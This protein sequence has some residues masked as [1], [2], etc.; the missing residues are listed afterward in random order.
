MSWN[1]LV[2]DQTRSDSMWVGLLW[3]KPKF[4]KI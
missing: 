1:L 3:S 2:S 4:W